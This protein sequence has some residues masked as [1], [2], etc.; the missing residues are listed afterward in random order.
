MLYTPAINKALKLTAK[1]HTDQLDKNE[2]PYLAHPLHLAEQ[3]DTE[4]EICAALLHDV[5]E[6]SSITAE[7]L[8]ARGIPETAVN[9]ILLLTHEEGTPYLDY[10]QAIQDGDYGTKKPV[11][12]HDAALARLY[13]AG[14]PSV[15]PGENNP[16]L[17]PVAEGARI[18]R[19]VKLADLKHNSELGRL[20]IVSSRDIKRLKKYREA[21]VI[22]GDL[23]YKARTPVGSFTVKVNGKPFAFHT[24]RKMIKAQD[25][26]HYRVEYLFSVDVVSLEQNDK[27]E[28]EYYF[29]GTLLNYESNDTSV[30]TT[31]QKGNST[32]VFSASTANKF[33]YTEKYPFQLLTRMGT[34]KITNDPIKYRFYPETHTIEY[35]LLLDIAQ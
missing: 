34:Y 8:V 16:N 25:A 6:D 23:V 30:S 19:K 13:H 14:A 15:D 3:M 11:D 24:E 1:L 21:R 10:V 9:A 7:E 31:Y 28:A 26:Q 20:S 4:A 12:D 27:V 22:L 33:A 32:I 29:G 5:L 18:A 17:D 2:V 35:R